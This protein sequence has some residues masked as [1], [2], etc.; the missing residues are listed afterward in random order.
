[1]IG[2]RQPLDP[3]V[4]IAHPKDPSVLNHELAYQG[5]GAQ[6]QVLAAGDGGIQEGHRDT[7]PSTVGAG[8]VIGADAVLLRTI[9]VI[10]H[11][12]AAHLPGRLHPGLAHDTAALLAGHLE[13]AAAAVIV[14]VAILVPLGALEQRKHLVIA[15]PRAALLTGYGG[16]EV[17]RT[18]PTLES[19]EL[20]EDGRTAH[21]VLDTVELGHVH[22]FDV[23]ALRSASGEPPLHRDAYYTVNR[24][25]R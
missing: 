6:L 21:L 20:S 1:M 7:A 8:L 11:R 15:P 4:Y 13:G 2:V 19:V 23:S 3:V 17:D 25:P 16:P 5:V 18:T 12:G 9:E 24:L 10:D 22:E 14:A